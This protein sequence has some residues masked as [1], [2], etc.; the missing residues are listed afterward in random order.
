MTMFSFIKN[1][2]FS[3]VIELVYAPTSSEMLLILMKQFIFHTG[4]MRLR[5]EA[6]YQS[7]RANILQD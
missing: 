4:K 1:N 7:H 5:T 6:G 2:Q 3:K